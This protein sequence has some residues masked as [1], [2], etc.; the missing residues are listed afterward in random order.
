MSYSQTIVWSDIENVLKSSCCFIEQQSSPSSSSLSSN[1]NGNKR[2]RDSDVSTPPLTNKNRFMS[3]FQESFHG[4]KTFIQFRATL[5]NILNKESG[6][7]T[8]GGN[9]NMAQPTATMNKTS[10]FDTP[11]KKKRSSSFTPNSSSFLPSSNASHPK[12]SSISSISSIHSISSISSVSDLGD[13]LQSS[14]L[15]KKKY[16]EEETLRIEKE[17]E[18]KQKYNQLK[19]QFNKKIQCINNIFNQAEEENDKGEYDKAMKMLD[20]DAGKPIEDLDSLLMSNQAS[21]E[22]NSFS[23]EFFEYQILI[24]EKIK[25]KRDELLE[26]T[27]ASLVEY[28]EKEYEKKKLLEKEQEKDSQ[29]SPALSQLLQPITNEEEAMAEEAWSHGY[30][31]EK[32]VVSLEA[33]AGRSLV[34]ILG[35]HTFR[36]RD[37]WLVDEVINGY[38]FLLQERDRKRCSQ[39][40]TL[41]PTHF[42]S[43]FFFEKMF[44]E[45][46]Y[47]YASVKRWGRKVSGGNIFKMGKVVIPVNLSNTHWCLCFVDFDK[48]TI[49]YYDSMG[50][51]GNRYL[52]GMRSYLRDEGKKFVG[53]DVPSDLLDMETWTLIPT[54][55]HDQQ[56]NVITPQQNNGNDCG[57]FT[58]TFGNLLSVDEPLN[59]SAYDMPTI[60]T[61]ITLD[62]LNKEIIDARV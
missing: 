31:S 19:K 32:V 45:G 43:S 20:I 26:Y 42:F 21:Y 14:H 2:L 17:K 35:Q 4:T 3:R 38:M 49:Q 30:H 60:R 59:F 52:N 9:N 46:G 25:K 5:N 10:A 22:T 11:N 23:L 34:D 55:V 33:G 16:D 29:L 18:I 15:Q 27:H 13:L 47:K 28:E 24:L 58:C 7:R 50:G 57:V 53:T 6:D 41:K 48:K 62:I 40:P 37:G 12:P 1:N 54:I 8:Y 44:E 61:R 36:L 51:S 56:G 39:D